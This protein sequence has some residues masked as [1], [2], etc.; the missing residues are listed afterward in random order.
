MTRCRP[1]VVNVVAKLAVAG[2]VVPASV[3]EFVPADEFKGS[4]V[5]AS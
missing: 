3:A 5:V 1:A 2:F 4:P